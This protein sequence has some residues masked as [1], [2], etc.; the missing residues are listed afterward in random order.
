MRSIILEMPDR[1]TFRPIAL[2][3]EHTAIVHARM[4]IRLLTPRTPS[5]QGRKILIKIDCRREPAALRS[6]PIQTRCAVRMPWS[7][8]ALTT[9]ALREPAAV[10]RLPEGC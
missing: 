9:A 2:R 1:P 3:P 7:R 4:N 10:L 6:T 5:A 8:V